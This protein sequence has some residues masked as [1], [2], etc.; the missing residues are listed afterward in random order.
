MYFIDGNFVIIQF[1]EREPLDEKDWQDKKESLRTALLEM[2]GERYFQLWLEET[3]N[4]MIERGELEIVKDI[5]S[6]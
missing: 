2:K 1:K 6:L 3:K 4:L 5:E